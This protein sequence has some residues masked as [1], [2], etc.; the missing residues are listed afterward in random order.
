MSR[1]Y[2]M[3]EKAY[4]GMKQHGKGKTSNVTGPAKTG[5]VGTNY[6]LSLTR[7][8]LSTGT[9]YLYSVTCLV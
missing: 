7:S 5:R 6:T 2:C 4:L 9:E 1:I 8:F 3:Y